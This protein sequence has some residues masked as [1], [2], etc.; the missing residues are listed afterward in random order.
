MTDWSLALDSSTH[1]RLLR[2]CPVPVLARCIEALRASELSRIHK[3]QF[4]DT[5]D[6]PNTVHA[7]EKHHNSAKEK[8]KENSHSSNGNLRGLNKCGKENPHVYASFV[9]PNRTCCDRYEHAYDRAKCPAS[10][11]TCHKCDEQ[12]H[13][14]KFQSI[15]LPR[16]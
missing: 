8:R 4:K 3:E 5:D 16:M 1:D 13:F 14:L 6:S 7:A 2:E 12:G 15:M 10:G 11:K 9:A